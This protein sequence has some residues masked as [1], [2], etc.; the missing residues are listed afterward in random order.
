M[1]R[2]VITFVFDDGYERVWRNAVPLLRQHRMPAV[3]ALSL[4]AQHLEK[5]AQ[6]KIKPWSQWVPLRDEGHEL[7]SHSV[8][9]PNLTELSASQLE[10][11]LSKAA[12][13]LS[14]STLVYPGGA[15]ND[16]VV[17]A[18]RRYYTAARTV[19]HGLETIPPAD[20]MRLKSYNFSR[21][22][23]SVLRANIL[24]SLAWLTN[25]WLIETYHMVDDEEGEMIHWVKTNQLKQHLS[26]VAHLPIAVKTIKE[27]IRSN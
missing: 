19:H 9:H 17:E 15:F 23:F 4:S 1:T 18:A 12:H 13:Q 22:N 8:S 26:F 14:A 27:V 11:E 16:L 24:A 3:F 10:R 6:S 21:K 5:S 20:P 2:G 7:A 25:S